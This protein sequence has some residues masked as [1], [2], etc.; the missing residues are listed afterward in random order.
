MVRGAA[1]AAVLAAATFSVLGCRGNTV[2]LTEFQRVRSGMLDVVLLSPGDALHHGRDTFFVEFRSASDGSLV[3][4]GAVKGSA[5]MPMAGTPM[6]ASV[7]VKRTNVP[8]RYEAASDFSMAG[9][10]R[11]TIEWNG[12]AGQGSVTL[13]GN[14]Q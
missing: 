11:T 4:V 14:V 7:D 8:G 3:D 2:K 1:A 10:W 9:T 13:S 5:T 6:I 12:P